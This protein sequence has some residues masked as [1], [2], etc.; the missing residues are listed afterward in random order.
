MTERCGGRGNGEATARSARIP[1]LA[2]TAAL[3][4]ALTGCGGRRGQPP[5]RPPIVKDAEGREYH[6]LDRGPY[7]AYYDTWG[8]LQRVDYDDNGD[9]RAD[10]IAHHDGAR[11]PHLIE[12]DEDHDGNIDRWEKYGVDGV[13]L[14]AGTASRPGGGPEVWT[15]PG[16]DGTPKRREYDADGDGRAERAEI[17]EAGV[18]VAVELDLDRDG[19]PDRWQ[20]WRD[21]RLVSEDADTDGDGHPDVRIRHGAGGS[22]EAERLPR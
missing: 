5:D 1:H 8:R 22:V 10:H 14:K 19:R 7:K 12:I 3:L 4:L 6:L 11:M 20:S 17:L 21:G 13:L 9:G 16:P 18:V 2:G 15:V